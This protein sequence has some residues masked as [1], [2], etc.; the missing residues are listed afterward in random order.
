MRLDAW[1]ASLV[2]RVASQ[3][4]R[5]CVGPRRL[6]LWTRCLPH[7]SP[8]LSHRLPGLDPRL[9]LVGRS[10]SPSAKCL[11]CLNG[12][13][14][15]RCSRRRGSRFTMVVQTPVHPPSCPP[16]IGYRPVFF[17][18]LQTICCCL[19]YLLFCMYSVIKMSLYT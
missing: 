9:H 5:Q 6:C 13:L 19:L 3:G 16:F 1:P 18:T 10:P 17:E 11:G 14:S 12:R 2:C 8:R 15:D 4:R 7:R